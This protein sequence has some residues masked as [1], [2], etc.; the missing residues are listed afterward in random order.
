MATFPADDNGHHDK[1]WRSLWLSSGAL[2]I[3]IMG[4]ALIYIVLPVNAETFGIGLAWIG[5]LQPL[6]RNLIWRDVGAAA[7]PLTNSF[8]RLSN[9]LRR[10]YSLGCRMVAF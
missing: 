8:Y 10:R 2:S 3:A 5:V 9:I 4:D 6:A 7:G 1:S